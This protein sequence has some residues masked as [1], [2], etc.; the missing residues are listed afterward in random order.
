M[1]RYLVTSLVLFLVVGGSV[2]TLNEIQFEGSQVETVN[3]STPRDGSFEVNG[4]VYDSVVVFRNDDVIGASSSF[5]EVNRV[6]V[7]NGVPVT[8]GII[9]KS[10]NQSDQD[11]ESE[12][13]KLRE[14]KSKNSEIVYFSA[15]GWDH[16]GLEFKEASWNEINDKLDNIDRFGQG[17]L[18]KEFNV[19]VPP[20]NSMSSEAR[21]LLNKSGYTVISADRKMS[22]QTADSVITSNR[23]KFLRRRPLELGQ[24][25][26]MVDRW[27]TE[28]VTF[29]NLS[30]LKS[31]FNESVENHEIFVQTVHH[32]PIYHNDR[33]ED[34]EALITHM[35]ER[36]VY[37]ASL[38][39][40][41]RLFAEDRIRRTEQG[42][43][44]VE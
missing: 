13:R 3:V 23:S 6:F 25:S 15:H 9:P 34:L 7:E 21:I 35:K 26:M 31:D 2:L 10:F 1:F 39:D 24:S 16:N 40:L 36:N 22:W 11:F 12:C 29:R 4:S 27:D 32:S 33:T 38:N 37:F 14:L 8:H 42:W 20:H 28:P 30:D 44:I 43:L 19:F 18:N 41:S 17:C 5:L